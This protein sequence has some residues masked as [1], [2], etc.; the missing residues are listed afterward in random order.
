M[1]NQTCPTWNGDQICGL[2]LILV[3]RDFPSA[4]EIYECPLGHRKHVALGDNEKRRCP[5][6]VDRKECGLALI[7]VAREPENATQIYECPM[8]HRTYLPL[9][10]ESLDDGS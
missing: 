9:Q 8:G 4:T 10:P 3:E 5:T 7:A 6:V 2:A 1:E